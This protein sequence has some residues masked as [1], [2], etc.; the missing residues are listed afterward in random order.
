M[1]ISSV[2]TNT[3]ASMSDPPSKPDQYNGAATAP[4]A[5]PSRRLLPALT[6]IVVAPVFVALGFWQLDR[7]RQKR[8]LIAAFEQGGGAPRSLDEALAEGLDA[9]LY[10]HVV[11]DGHYLGAE[12]FLLDGQ[13]EGDGQIGYDV[14]TPFVLDGDRGTILVNRGFIG[15]DANRKPIGDTQVGGEERQLRARIARLPRAGFKL[16]PASEST[17]PD[18]PRVMLYPDRAE[19]ESA[20]Q[21]PVLAPILWLDADQP[22][23]YLRQ[24]RVTDMTP[25]RHVAYA[26]Q[27]FAFAVTLVA[28]YFIV[29][30][31]RAT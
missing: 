8:E 9:A 17:A 24:W 30:R 1:P 7:A 4:A 13:I 25:Q 26:L 29:H 10:R 22:D 11:V 20:L 6:V 27:W 3:R 31:R 5:R 23:G 19:L 14:L 21:Q 16:G 12:Q 18:W 2:M 28:I 15:Q